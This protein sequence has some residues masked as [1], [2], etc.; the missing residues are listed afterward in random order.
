M[1]PAL[2]SATVD[3][4]VNEQLLFLLANVKRITDRR[5]WPLYCRLAG[6]MATAGRRPNPG[7]S[8]RTLKPAWYGT[9]PV[10]IYIYKQFQYMNGGSDPDSGGS[11]PDSGGSGQVFFCMNLSLGYKTRMRRFNKYER[12]ANF[13]YATPIEDTPSDNIPVGIAHY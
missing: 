5:D 11:D 12:S 4:V 2:S 7:I 13:L 9:L 8:S 1:Y 10:Y 6:R 3:S